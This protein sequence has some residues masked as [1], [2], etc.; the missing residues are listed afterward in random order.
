V[1][2]W[3]MQLGESDE[4]MAQATATHSAAKEN[5]KVQRALATPSTGTSIERE[6][7]ALT[8]A[9]YKL[10]LDALKEAEFQKTLLSLK[11]KQWE[12]GID[13]WRS[14]NANMRH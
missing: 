6:R 13:V 1:E 12:L 14:L 7:A 4:A 8:S 10:A 9:Q 5:L 2:K 11:R 3:L